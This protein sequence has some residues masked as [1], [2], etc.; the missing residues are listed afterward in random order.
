MRI[1]PALLFPAL[2]AVSAL[3]H[4]WLVT[5][6]RIAVKAP[7]VELPA[8]QT[9][10][11]FLLEEIPPAPT[12]VPESTPEP[13]PPEPELTPVHEDI[14]TATES[15]QTVELPPEPEPT[16]R[17]T[18]APTPK[19]QPTPKAKPTPDKKPAPPASTKS[20]ARIANV[21]QPVVIRNTPP[22][23]PEI[24]RRSGWEGRAIIRVEVS[25]DGRP[26]STSIARSSG[27]GVL[28][29][30]ALRAVKSWRFQ[31]RTV[32]GI[33]TTGTVEVPVNFSLNR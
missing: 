4:V 2:L 27:Y 7:R 24:A 8:E 32:S 6:S 9:T 29:Q 12:P 23:Y 30:S 21:P 22:A 16:P 25:A 26:L 31:P 20:S 18:P 5:S 17:P 14:V 33:P 19:P 11:V 28:D 3:A 15:A 13:R 10:E 1:K